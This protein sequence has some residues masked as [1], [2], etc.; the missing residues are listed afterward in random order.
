MV[1][2][3][4]E[5]LK[6]VRSASFGCRHCLWV[7]GNATTLSCS[8]SIWGELVKDAV[9]RR[10]FFDWD[11]GTSASPAISHSTRPIEPERDGG[12]SAFDICDALGSLQLA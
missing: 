2:C 4:L 3:N 8:G 1:K 12:A 11:D 10:C 6:P 5:Y 7:L 9:E